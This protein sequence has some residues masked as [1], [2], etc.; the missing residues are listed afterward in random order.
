MDCP[1]RKLFV[2][3]SVNKNPTKQKP[4]EH[5]SGRGLSLFYHLKDKYKLIAVCKEIFFSTLGG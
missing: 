1:Q 2:W 5:K 4:T 3:A